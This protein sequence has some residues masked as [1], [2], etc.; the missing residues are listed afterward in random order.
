MRLNHTAG[1]AA[2]NAALAFLQ[3]NGCTLLARNWHCAYGEI[4]LIVRH[5]RQ[6]VFVEVKYRKNNRFGGAA[7]SITPAKLAKLQRSAELYLQ[8]HQLH[9]THCRLDAVLIQGN[10]TPLWLHNITG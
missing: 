5:G 2:E 6:L 10:D 4:D 8:Q 1:V 3:K 9:H 7:H